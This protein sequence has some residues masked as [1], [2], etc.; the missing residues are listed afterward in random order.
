MKVEK[1]YLKKLL[2]HQVLP[3]S[4]R[5]YLSTIKVSKQRVTLEKLST[6]I[7]EDSSTGTLCYI[8]HVKPVAFPASS[9]I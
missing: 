3:L 7:G 5:W 2:D 6:K 9:V 4:S 8:C 1:L